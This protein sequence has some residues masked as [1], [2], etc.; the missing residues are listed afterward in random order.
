MIK[1]IIF[2]GAESS[3]KTTISEELAKIYQTSVVP[4]FGREYWIRNHDSDGKLTSEQL[5]ELAEEHRKSEEKIF[6]E[7]NRIVFC[8]TGASTTK[9]FCEFY[10]NSVPA[11]LNAMVNEEKNRYDMFVIC[12]SDIPFVQD[13]TR[14]PKEIQESAETKI[15]NDLRKR[16]IHFIILSGSLNN[17]I[18]VMKSMIRRNFDILP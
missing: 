13:G 4:E 11:E 9:H 7:S 15:I 6:P 3:G 2:L 5:L 17:R 18:Q 16:H 10:G 12:S 1:K 8:D 14:N